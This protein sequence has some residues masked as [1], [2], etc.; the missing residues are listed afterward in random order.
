[1]TEI[2]FDLNL[3]E[4]IFGSMVHTMD[5]SKNDIFIISEQNRESFEEMKKE[6]EEV[7]E[8]MIVVTTEG[9]YLETMTHDSR[10]RLADV[11]KNFMKYSEV[12]VREAYEVANDLLVRLSVNRMEERRLR[13]RREDLE[14]RL[15]A[16]LDT[17][18]RADQLIS[19]VAIVVNYL[20][21]DL[22]N[23]GVALA[24]AKHKQDYGIRIIQAQEEERKRLSRDIHDGPA[25]T[26]A[27]VL[28]RCGL[29]EKMYAEK[30]PEPAFAEMADLKLT[31][32]D[33]LLEVRRIIYDLRPM[34]LDDLGL[35]PTLRK[36]L[37]KIGEFEKNINI[38]FEDN[39]MKKRLHTDFEVAVFRLVQESVT[40]SLKHG[41]VRDIWVRIEVLSCVLNI[42]VEDNGKGFNPQKVHDK[43]FG[44][45]GMRERIDLLKGNMKISSTPGNGTKIDFQI[46][47]KKDKIDG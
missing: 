20:T 22:K 2:K 38:H 18:E 32:K 46:P 23:V 21:S 43:S 34:A 14:K 25:Q 11:S 47:L 44:L 41:N 7:K 37:S 35:I 36:Y 9:N 27:T 5:Q 30:G 12:Q 1:M 16:L 42:V 24:N 10:K 45:I 40:N 13:E 29:I 17:I 15:A 4:S 6:L 8:S 31:V 39:G 26:L 19:Q 28:L 33:A 3:L